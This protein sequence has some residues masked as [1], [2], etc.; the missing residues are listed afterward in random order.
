MVLALYLL[1][2][3]PEKDI[4]ASMHVTAAIEIEVPSLQASTDRRPWVSTLSA[5]F[6]TFLNS[7][8]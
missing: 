1:V 6:S 4:L 3:L 5:R 7:M 2:D 8:R